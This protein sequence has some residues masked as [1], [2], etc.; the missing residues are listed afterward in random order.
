MAAQ[1]LKEAMA[2]RGLS[3]ADLGAFFG[4]S[5]AH[6]ARWMN[7]QNKVHW[8]RLAKLRDE[9]LCMGIDT[10]AP[11]REEL[12]SVEF[13]QKAN[14]ARWKTER[15]LWGKKKRPKRYLCAY[16]FGLT[17]KQ[18][19]MVR[20][21]GGVS[22]KYGILY[23]K[24]IDFAIHRHPSRIKSM[25]QLL[26]MSLEDLRKAREKASRGPITTVVHLAPKKYE[27]LVWLALS[28]G[29]TIEQTIKDCIFEYYNLMRGQK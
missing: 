2:E 12:T 9:F 23:R 4:V 15:K 19:T 7:H 11:I 6:A 27:K 14:L 29:M 21:L 26:G 20:E 24:I 18:F 17:H 8:T 22:G 5:E 28:R 16:S 10:F 3:A 13:D 1:T 25:R